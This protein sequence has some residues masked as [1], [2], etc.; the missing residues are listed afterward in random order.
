MGDKMSFGFPL[1]DPQKGKRVTTD[2]AEVLL[3]SRLREKREEFEDAVWQLARLYSANK[4]QELAAQYIS[5]LMSLT[6]DPERQ[7]AYWLALGQ[8]MEKIH[9]YEEAVNYY[10][11]AF[12]MEPTGTGSW[13]FINNNLGYSLIQLGQFVD[14][15]PYC[16]AAIETDPRMHNAYKNLGL[17]LQ[18]QGR[19]PEA[20]RS[21]IQAISA[22][23]A[24]PRALRHLEGLLEEHPDLVSEVP[25][26]IDLLAKSRDAVQFATSVTE[27]ATKRELEGFRDLTHAEKILLAL[28]RIVF[29]E[30][31][32]EFSRDDVR[33]TLGLSVE[34]WMSG[35]TAVF[36]AMREDQPG[37]A[38]HI[39]EKYRSLLR[40][41]RHG[42]H[43]LTRQG[44]QVVR[45]I[46]KV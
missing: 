34:D 1:P 30:G 20:A 21:Y 43:A 17:S 46:H 41:V 2:E 19:Y 40:K 31:R 13:Y 35:Y 11:Q 26:I 18:G 28:N 3:L 12:S 6:D 38:P 42:V 9:N 4:R 45:D 32:V 5:L 23:A 33:R 39:N 44:H 37:G 25:E 22:N 15:E 7:A 24:D 27:A 29:L 10:K 16:R 8:S 36:Q 14:A